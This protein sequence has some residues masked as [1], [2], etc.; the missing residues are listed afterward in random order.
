MASVCL[1]IYCTLYSLD[2]SFLYL[3]A[4]YSTDVLR[5]FL[6]AIGK[7]PIQEELYM[8]V[9]QELQT[10]K[11]MNLRLAEID[12]DCSLDFAIYTGI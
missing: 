1:F 12:I 9:S 11:F 8:A 3:K 4:T 6:S 2:L 10:I 7:Y 5:H